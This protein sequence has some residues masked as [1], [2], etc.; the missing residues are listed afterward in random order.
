MPACALAKRLR[1]SCGILEA[2][3]HGDVL[4]IREFLEPVRIAGADIVK[5]HIAVQSLPQARDGAE[6][7]RR[8]LEFIEPAR[9]HDLER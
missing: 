9:E 2:V 8:I 7:Q 5:P 1:H 3:A 4:D 6:H